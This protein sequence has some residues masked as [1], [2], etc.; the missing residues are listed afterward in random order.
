LAFKHNP[1]G[2]LGENLPRRPGSRLSPARLGV[3][4][5]A[6]ALTLVLAPALAGSAPAPSASPAAALPDSVVARTPLRDITLDGMRSAWLRLDP[7]YRPEGT[8]EVLK[9][10]F[11]EQLLEKEAMAQAALAEPFVMT[12]RETAQFAAFRDD[13]VRRELYKILV[14]DSA[15]VLPVDRDSARARMATPPDGSPI[16]AEAIDGAAK[17][18]AQR[19]R[20]QV[21]EA[22]IKASV[23]P[24]FDDAVA[25]RLAGAYAAADSSL[26]DLDQPF[27]AALR[28][29]NPKLAPGDSLQVLAR[30]SVGDL[31]V[32]EFVRRFSL[33][34][35]F[36]APL[37]VT[38]GTVK[39]RGEQFLGQLWFDAEVRRRGVAERPGVRA[40]LAERRESIALD[41]WYER[42]VRAAIDTSEA[43]LRKHYAADLSR[44]GVSAH[45]I[46]KNW[47]VPT[48]ATA[49]SVVAVLAAGAPWDSLCARFG[50]SDPERESCN[51]T[52]SIADDAP[53]SALVANLKAL[54][55][56]RAYVRDESAQGIFRVVLLVT[57]NP[58]RIRPFEEA[59]TFVARDLAG[60]QAE[61]LL[62]AQMAAARKA[63]AVTVNDRA[64]SRLT[65]EP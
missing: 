23:A 43:A 36:Q 56:G 50:K 65:L 45:S 35:P 61:D 33:L 24:M 31:T 34:N 59:R 40:A 16:P 15:V 25:G 63:L 5:T 21:V 1:D 11:L 53:D 57:H 30:S 8:G 9:R 20:A 2:H 37:P 32:G 6:L 64:L 49:D 42:H 26:P 62:V 52:T 29:R 47:A 28:G 48:R 44:F 13:V 51:R 17:D 55:P 41:H 46:V 3:G 60:R 38:A 12:D 10:A 58:A 39:A 14:V 4:S 18:W 22:A 7:R 27:Q 54:S 19:R